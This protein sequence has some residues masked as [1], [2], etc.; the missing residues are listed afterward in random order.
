MKARNTVYGLLRGLLLLFAFALGTPLAQAQNYSVTNLGSPSSWVP[1][2]GINA[3]GQVAFQDYDSS[4]NSYRTFFFNGTSSQNIGSLGA[5]Y[6]DTYPSAINTSGQVVGNAYDAGYYISSAFSWTQA[7][8]MVNLGTLGGTN[9]YAYDVNASG[10]VVGNA[11]PAGNGAWRAFS[12]T[13]AGGMVD[14]GTLG[15]TYSSA[16]AVSASGQVVGYAYT[17]GNTETRA[18][19][20][21]QAGGMVDLGLPA[22]SPLAYATGV[23]NSGQVVGAF[24]TAGYAEQ[25]AFSWTQAGGMVDLGTLG[26]TYTYP[27]AVTASG[28]V[29]GLSQTA[30]GEQRAF[31]WTQA[32]GMVD[33]G[34]LGAGYTYAYAA[35]DLGQAVGVSY[36]A[37]YAAIRAFS[38]TQAGGMVDLNTRIPSAPPGMELYYG[39]AIS[40]N[41][42]FI[43]AYAN[44]GT[45]RLGGSS[46]APALGPIAASDPVAVG[47]QVAVSAGFTDAD[48]A[49]TH[50]AQWTWDDA[51]SEYGI[52][53]ES[54]GAGTATGTHVY[55]AAGVYKVGLL[56]TDSTG[57]TA[58]VSRDVVVY[59]P[60]AGFVTGGGWINSPAGA[61]KAEPM[62]VGRATFGFVSKYLK[63]ATKPSGKTE[64][65]FQAA[66]L[67]FHSDNYDWLV[68]AGAR[69][70]YKGVG[71]INGAGSFK[72]LLTAI[73]G[74]LTGGGGVDRFRIKIWHYDATLQADVVDYDNQVGAGEG[75]ATEGTVIGG[76]SIVIHKK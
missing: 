10:Q 58:T 33:I 76:G 16:N 30:G 23:N 5:S 45:V 72:F 22:G 70:Q 27:I 12:W 2:K 40:S 8:G 20:W 34:T 49:D 25:R 55:G 47:A 32:G 43:A 61:Y 54:A 52:V 64:F 14:L 62:L 35:S 7:G 39:L 28:Q 1:Q 51:T 73:D 18:F 13:Q 9:S 11:H 71:T 75:T 63:G 57:R 74:Q 36:T 19:S 46:T 59:D 37:G 41:G 50:T 68:V 29:I 67:N 24:Y 53:S 56:V 48:A 4:S 69:A 38:W 66:K 26:G 60:S 42:G 6:K 21:T 17:V 31:S 3:S 44:T 15:G 65:Q